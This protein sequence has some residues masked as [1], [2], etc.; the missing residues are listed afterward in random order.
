ML[1]HDYF[2]TRKMGL[3]MIL[4]VLVEETGGKGLSIIKG[5]LAEAYTHQD[6]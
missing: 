1:F 4:G 6:I 3:K 5:S 2:S